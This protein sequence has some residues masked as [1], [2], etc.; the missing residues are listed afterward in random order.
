MPSFTRKAIMG[1]FM[2]LLNDRPVNKIAVKDIVEACGINRNTFYY[3]FQDIPS[4]I[5]A[6]AKE[7]A[8]YVINKYARVETY[9]QCLSIVVEFILKNRKATLHLYNSSNRDLY[10]RYL[11]D[12]CQY[13]VET[14]FNTAFANRHISDFDRAVIVTSYKCHAYGLF[15]DWLNNGLQ[16][17]LLPKLNRLC[18]LREGMIEEIFKRA[19]ASQNN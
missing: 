4:L 19:E 3:H 17:D 12:I 6:I 1:A 15:I 16:E 5:E 2:Q 9:E 10:D 7:E 14:Y 11:M 8:D 18:E 13:V